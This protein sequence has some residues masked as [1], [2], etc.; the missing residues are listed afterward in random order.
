MNPEP[1]NLRVQLT[2]SP[3]PPSFPRPQVLWKAKPRRVLILKRLGPELLSNVVKVVK[4]LVNEGIEAFVEPMV[5]NE[6]FDAGYDAPVRTWAPHEVRR[7]AEMVD[8]VVCLGGDGVILHASYLFRKH[9][10][11]VR[12]GGVQGVAS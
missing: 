9:C 8:F 3:L 11:P 12:G 10:P 4:F 2:H 1:S 6:L 5:C 7:L